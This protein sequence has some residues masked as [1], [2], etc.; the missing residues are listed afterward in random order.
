MS[1]PGG[2]IVIQQVMEGEWPADARELALAAINER[3]KARGAGPLA[4][5]PGLCEAAEEHV[6]GYGDGSQRPHDGFPERVRRRG[7]EQCDCGIRNAGFGN[8][9]E[10]VGAGARAPGEVTSLD[11]SPDPDEGHRRD[12][13]DPAFTHCGIAFAPN[14][15]VDSWCKGWAYV[16]EWGARCGG[17][18][19]PTP[20][21]DAGEDFMLIGSR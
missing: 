6:K 17:E 14:R 2:I 10:G 15:G 18:P 7:W 16:V 1:L 12:F 3:R 19:T 4:L 8:V 5:D 9:S 13:E 21:P 20:T 11:D